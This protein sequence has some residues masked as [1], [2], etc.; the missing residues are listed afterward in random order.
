MDSKAMKLWPKEE[1]AVVSHYMGNSSGGAG[2][3][4]YEA[5]GQGMC[6]LRTRLELM[7]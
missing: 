5:E 1:G 3:P 2:V 4:W 7:S 6:G